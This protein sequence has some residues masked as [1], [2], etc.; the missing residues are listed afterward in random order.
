M[1]S[2]RVIIF[3]SVRPGRATRA[4]SWNFELIPDVL[5]R[6]LGNSTSPASVEPFLDD[7]K[8][9]IFHHNKRERRV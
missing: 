5:P 2:Y 4:K 6:M 9:L 8:M 7:F 3:A 1:I